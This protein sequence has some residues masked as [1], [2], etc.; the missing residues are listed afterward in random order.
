MEHFN[1]AFNH[2][3]P[4]VSK[5]DQAKYDRIRDRMARARTRGSAEE[6]EDEKGTM[7]HE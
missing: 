4:S 5:K 6:G 1:Y 2:V 7:K 3:M